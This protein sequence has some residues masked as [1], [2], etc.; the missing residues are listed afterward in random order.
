MSISSFNLI[1]LFLSLEA[2][3]LVSVILISMCGQIFFTLEG[4][5]NYFFISAFSSILFFFGVFLI[6]LDLDLSLNY[7]SF[8]LSLEDSIG[9]SCYNLYNGYNLIILGFLSRLREVDIIWL[10]KDSW[11]LYKKDDSL[12]I[13]HKDITYKLGIYKDMDWDWKFLHISNINCDSYLIQD[14]FYE[15]EK[16]INILSSDSFS[17]DIN[18]ECESLYLRGRRVYEDWDMLMVND[19]KYIIFFFDSITRNN[20]FD[21]YYNRYN[22]NFADQSSIWPFMWRHE[23]EE[24]SEL[25]SFDWVKNPFIEYNVS[26]DCL[27]SLN[28]LDRYWIKNSFMLYN[29][30]IDNLDFV[31]ERWIGDFFILSD[32]RKDNFLNLE[33][34]N[35]N[36]FD[37]NLLSFLGIF[38]IFLF[39][40]IKLGLFPFN[41]WVPKLYNSI[42]FI[43]FIFIILIK[44]VFIISFFRLIG[45]LSFPIYNYF[46]MLFYIISLGSIIVGS[47]GAISS[48]NI[49]NFIA[50]TSIN[51]LGFLMMGFSTISW[52]A[53]YISFLFFIIYFFNI[54]FFLIPI[55][56]IRSYKRNV[57]KIS[58]NIF[59][60][61]FNNFLIYN[62]NIFLRFF[63]LVAFLSITGLPPFAS[64]V[65]KLNLLT[66][67]FICGNY[68]MVFCAVLT[69]FVSIFYY[70]KLII[71]L[72]ESKFT[73][74]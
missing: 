11:K 39:F 36:N 53:Q 62:K 48:S 8:R 44:F 16:R 24:G 25:M 29:S 51:N 61:K 63:F 57:F 4:L 60:S 41:F 50:F 74:R 69:T 65:V 26:G 73:N 19:L 42:W 6:F 32:Y 66:E 10:F 35:F 71:F 37:F 55:L 28:W 38:F 30:Y 27:N 1:L 54:I 14:F 49:K 21:T 2:L 12:S 43:L 7:F 23:P 5:L 18:I 40:I 59:F 3:T 68:F 22:Y 45:F 33:D 9:L 17:S 52:F 46:I 64:F 20:L 56:I 47:L 58:D 13:I 31:D 67:V 34:V 72:M 15:Y 70:F